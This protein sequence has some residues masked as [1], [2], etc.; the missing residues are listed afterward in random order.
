MPA[1][2]FV[3]ESDIGKNHDVRWSYL[4]DHQRAHHYAHL[5]IQD[6]KTRPEYRDPNLKMIVRNRDGEVIHIIPF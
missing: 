2:S 3:V 5:I 6:L 4:P 1:Y